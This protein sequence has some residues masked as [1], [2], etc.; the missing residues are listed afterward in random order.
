MKSVMVKDAR[1]LGSLLWGLRLAFVTALS[2]S[3]T[4]ELLSSKASIKLIIL[5]TYRES[6][7]TVIQLEK[8]FLS[9]GGKLILIKHVL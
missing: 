9:P 1:F 7:K 4:W 6:A 8:S 2:Y 3:P 5:M